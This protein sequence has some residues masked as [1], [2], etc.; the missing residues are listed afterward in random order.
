MQLRRRRRRQPLQLHVWEVV[1][2]ASIL[3]L[4]AMVE[5]VVLVVRPLQPAVVWLLLWVAVVVMAVVD[6]GQTMVGVLLCF[7]VD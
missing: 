2:E 4:V 1:M 3:W 5:A 6:L 7:W